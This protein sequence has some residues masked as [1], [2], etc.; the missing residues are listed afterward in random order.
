MNV[1]LAIMNWLTN[2][3][4]SKFKD[5]EKY[6]INIRSVYQ[7]VHTNHVWGKLKEQLEKL[8]INITKS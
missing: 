5:I 8:W 6:W 3:W 2:N 4:M 1:R 7:A